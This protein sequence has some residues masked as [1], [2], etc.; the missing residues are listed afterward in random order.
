[1]NHRFSSVWYATPKK[2]ESIIKLIAFNDRG[3]LEI[4]PDQIHFRG[5][6]FDVT[7]AELLAVS[8]KR[9]QIPWVSY[10][11]INVA[12]VVFLA[13]RHSPIQY[14]AAMV[15][16]LLFADV[17]GLLVGISTKWIMVEYRDSTDE[18]Q[19]AYF[20][21][22]SAF[23]WGGIFGGTTRLYRQLRKQLAHNGH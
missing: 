23:G 10:A 20:A 16:I 13:V 1:M 19:R 12:A 17:L 15:A 9:Q 2:I 3:S 8:L 7:I 22:G 11:I 5:K 14:L 6:K 4:Q 21:D 18:P